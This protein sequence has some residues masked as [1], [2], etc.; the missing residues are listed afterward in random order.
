MCTMSLKRSGKKEIVVISCVTFETAKVVSPIDYYNADKAYLLHYGDD[1]IY[2]EFYDRVV[3]MIRDLDQNIE[4][5]DWD[6]KKVYDFSEMLREILTILENESDVDT[7]VFINIS[8][9]TS[10]FSA[11]AVVASMMKP[12]VV[13]FTVSTEK[14]MVDG[15]RVR[16]VFFEDGLPVGMARSVKEPIMLPQYRIEMPPKS[17]VHGLKVLSDKIDN[18]KSI[19]AKNMIEALKEEG[20][21]YHEMIISP[22]GKKQ[23]NSRT[24]AVYYNRNFVKKW[25][26]KGWIIKNDLTRKHEITESGHL[27]LR[28][29]YLE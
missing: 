10:E 11:A 24:E 19:K 13:A 14:Y 15:E 29:F 22:N 5:I 17:L 28:T 18:K 23:D 26:D 3:G 8:A 9:G 6:G 12:G 20:L 7:E 1:N 25:M 27:I 2:R 16:E 21:W 4:I